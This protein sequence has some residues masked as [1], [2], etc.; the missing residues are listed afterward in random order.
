MALAPATRLGPYEILQS[1]GAGGMGEVYRARDTRLERIVAV[2]I[3]PPHLSSDPVG[4]QRFER[5]AKTISS[6]NHP[7]ICTLYDVGQQDGVDFLVME[8]VEGETLS[9][10]L[11][12]GPLPLEQ[13]LK[14]GAQ[15]ADALDKAHRA[16]IVHRDLKPGNIMITSAG[17]KLLDF[18]LAK[19]T[20]PASGMT[21]TAGATHTTPVT[22]EGMVVGTFQYMS[23]EQIEGKELDGRSDIFSLGAVL[24]EMLTGQKTFQGKSQLSVA[25]AILEKEPAPISSLKPLTPPSL[26]HSIR[27][28]LAK[29]PEERWQN[30]RDLALELKWVAEGDSQAGAVAPPASHRKMRT[31]LGWVSTAVLAVAL[32]AVVAVLYR[33]TRPVPAPLMRFSVDLGREVVEPGWGSGMAISPDGSQ[34]VFVSHDPNEPQRLFLR[35]VESDK[36]TPLQSTENARAPFFSPDG[37]WVAFF[38]DGKLKK[39]ATKGGVPTTLCEAPSTRGGSW[40]DD[41]S[42]IFAPSNRSALFRVSAAGGTAQPVTEL[43]GEWTQRYPQLLP[44]AKAFL[45]TSCRNLDFDTCAIEAQ[46]LSAGQRKVLV[47][48]GYYGR[49]VASGHLLYVHQGTLMAAPMDITRLELTG[50]ASPVLEDVESNLGTGAAHFDFSRSGTLVYISGK[51]WSQNRSLFW[52][53]ASGNLTPLGA[54]PQRTYQQIRV[55]PDGKLLALALAESSQNHLWIYELARERFYRL[56]FLNGNSENPLWTPDSKHLVFSSDAQP[57]GPGIYWIRA[58]GAGEAQRLLEGDNLI[59]RTFSPGGERL[60]YD[61]WGAGGGASVSWTLPLDTSNPDHP[62]TGKPE[63]FLASVGARPTFSP[64]GRWVAYVTSESGTPQIYVRPFSAS[65]GRWLVSSGGGGQDT[66][67]TGPTSGEGGFNAFWSP[68]GRELFYTNLEGRIM[69]VNFTAKGDTFS[70]DRPRVWSTRRVF[71]LYSPL[72]ANIDLAPDG[73][74]FAVIL[75]AGQDA[76]PQP[77]THV[78]FLLNFFDELR[79]RVPSQ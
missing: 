17:A 52:M 8:C 10:R 6:L 20:A 41:G 25:S 64:D 54:A 66:A 7:H 40:G 36:A 73:K 30:A 4:K 32:I 58:D 16:G 26:D 51:A 65:E 49:Y 39:I 77:R 34:L 29:D 43:R 9:E 63:K 11:E 33:A 14:F 12:K 60:A 37:Q 76:E 31:W 78:M 69:L 13:V 45:F 74:R 56:T 3:L 47:Q 57:P 75:P 50:P 72:A 42:I 79:R 68:N 38:A 53:N 61:A 27:R 71:V 21:L 19:P 23:P 59:P 15:I 35:V 18:G 67:Y 55:S 62:K 44:G 2:K 22:Q 5:E 1:I 70:A 28:C 46:F 24:Y 48:G